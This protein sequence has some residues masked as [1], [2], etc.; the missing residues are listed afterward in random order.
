VEVVTKV[1][2][3]GV[4]GPLAEEFCGGVGTGMCSS[5]LIPGEMGRV[6]QG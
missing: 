1:A 4:Q 6:G 2:G 5:G 3:G